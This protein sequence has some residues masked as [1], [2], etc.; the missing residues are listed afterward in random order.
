MSGQNAQAGNPAQG[1]AQDAGGGGAQESVAT[2]Q[3]QAA[4]VEQPAR[5]EQQAALA[6]QSQAARSDPGQKQKVIHM[7]TSAVARIKREERERGRR[8]ALAEVDGRLRKL[9]FSSIDDVERKASKGAA[10]QQQAPARQGGGREGPGDGERGSRDG[11]TRQLGAKLAQEVKERKRLER[12]LDAKDA[13]MELRLAATRAGVRDVDY[14][15]EMLRRQL[16]GKSEDELKA[17]DEGKFFTEEL[18]R[19]HPFLYQAVPQPATTG[20][21][22][23][24]PSPASA[25]AVQ[26]DAAR[27][28]TIDARKMPRDEYDKLLQKHNLANPSAG[29]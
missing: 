11:R 29:L 26:G 15:V 19:T 8:E 10:A 1:T 4:P 14:A 9:G 2:P 5:A 17:F 23:G 13:E 24:E 25:S 16:R 28:Q 20:A 3:A 18:K 12:E 7:P 21:G 6:E 27:S 22:G